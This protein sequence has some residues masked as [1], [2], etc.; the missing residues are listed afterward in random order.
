MVRECSLSRLLACSLA[1]AEK[2]R[3]SFFF[4]PWPKML[5][6]FNTKWRCG[7]KIMEVLTEV[8]GGC[9]AG[10]CHGAILARV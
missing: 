4:S 9:A 1:R 2:G 8:V 6:D 7:Q 3:L 5:S 10:K